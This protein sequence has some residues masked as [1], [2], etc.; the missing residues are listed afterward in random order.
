MRSLQLTALALSVLLMG[1][2]NAQELLNQV[3]QVLTPTGTNVAKAVPARKTAAPRKVKP[4]IPLRTQLV[5]MLKAPQLPLNKRMVRLHV[6]VP[7]DSDLQMEDEGFT[8]A[9]LPIASITKIRATLSGIGLSTPLSPVGADSNGDLTVPPDGL[10]VIDFE[11]PVGVNR[12]VSLSAYNSAGQL[13]EGSTI[14]GVLDI[15]DT[16]VNVAEIQFRTTPAATVLEK[17]IVADPLMASLTPMAQ[18]QTFIDTQLTQPVTGSVPMTFQTHPS[19]VN[20]QE[21]FQTIV[22][23]NANQPPGSPV[24]LPQSATPEML[25]APH[26]L[27]GLITIQEG[28]DEADLTITVLDPASAYPG[29][30]IKGPISTP[31]TLPFTISGIAPNAP[32]HPWIVKLS[33]TVSGQK[34]FSGSINRLIDLNTSSNVSFTIW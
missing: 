4:L 23:I 27:Q 9:A 6:V 34:L 14:K 8:I 18:L 11:V 3:N 29:A 25:T 24:I 30:V 33:G 5:E 10:A 12:I 22:N 26:T 13:V 16:S 31:I 19:L 15:R 17:L 21:I 32:G 20:T 1:C 28:Y 2:Q 7:L